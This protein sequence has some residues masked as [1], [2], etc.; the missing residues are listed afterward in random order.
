MIDP[1]TPC[2]AGWRVRTLTAS[3]LLCLHS[4]CMPTATMDPPTPCE[5][6]W[7]VRAHDSVCADAAID[8]PTPCEAGWRVR[9]LPQPGTHP[10]PNLAD[11]SPY[12]ATGHNQTA[13][14]SRVVGHKLLFGQN[15]KPGAA[16]QSYWHGNKIWTPTGPQSRKRGHNF[17]LPEASGIISAFAS[18]RDGAA[19]CKQM[20]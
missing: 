12:N 11:G 2:E 16:A 18:A 7:R 4:S 19:V 15:G 6:R 13:A 14:P 20:A 1:P 5:A 8:P 9:P 17:Q 10:S 3:A